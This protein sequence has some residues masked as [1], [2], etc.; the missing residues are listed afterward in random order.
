MW[1][2]PSSPKHAEFRRYSRP[3]KGSPVY[4]R[5]GATSALAN[6]LEPIWKN[7]GAP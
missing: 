3:N 4:G 7:I 6:E 1:F 5:Y 2:V